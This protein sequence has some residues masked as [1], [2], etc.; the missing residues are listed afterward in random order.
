MKNSEVIYPMCVIPV[1]SPFF[2]T[3]FFCQLFIFGA[4]LVRFF[5]I[6]VA[7]KGNQDGSRSPGEG[8]TRIL[9]AL[10]PGAGVQGQRP[11]L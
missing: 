6:L 1:T 3:S 5:F 7:T 10:R 11:R 4:A 8:D 9:K 2:Q